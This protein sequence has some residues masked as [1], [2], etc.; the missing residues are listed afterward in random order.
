MPL[1]NQVFNLVLLQNMFQK[2]QTDAQNAASRIQPAAFWT[3]QK[4]LKRIIESSQIVSNK[5]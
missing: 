3:C 5:S 1:K 4:L 2:Q